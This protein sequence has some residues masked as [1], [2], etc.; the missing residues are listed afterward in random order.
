M[1]N[2][3]AKHETEGKEVRG[4]MKPSAP[5]RKAN[6]EE[7]TNQS[8][9]K[10]KPTPSMII[11]E[12]DAVLDK[13][14]TEAIIT[15]IADSGVSFQVVGR[16]SF[17]SLMKTASRRIKLKSPKTYVRL[18]R[19]RAKEIDK[20]ICDI[21]KTIREEGNIKSMGFTTDIWTST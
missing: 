5:K 3:E 11:Q 10:I 20:S 2:L 8:G 1:I 14:I 18:T 7:A 15:F 9:P 16:D 6:T 17:V 4:K 21:N 12:S 19:L 13:R